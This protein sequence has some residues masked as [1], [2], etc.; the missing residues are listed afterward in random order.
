MVR[1]SFPILVVLLAAC[2]SGDTGPTGNDTPFDFSFDD[3]A[4]DTVAVVD[5]PATA[6]RAT[7][8]VSV[9]GSVDGD[10]VTLALR[11]AEPV[12]PWS[13]QAPNS[14][15]GFVDFDLDQST[16]SGVP[17]AGESAGGDPLLGV[18][19]YLDLRDNGEG[20][21]GLVDAVKRSFITLPVTFNGA[22]LRLE[23]PR[24]AFGGKGGTFNFAVTVGDRDRL[25]SDL[26]PDTG[27]YTATP[28]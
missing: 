19:F 7:D 25:A 21:I 4:G 14:L 5:L 23:I 24:S 20:R 2:G 15:D 10:K 8:L 13:Q 12:V 9:S 3:A 16:G 17:G 22:E 6:G 11:F 26:G 27:H 18:E 1:R 28:P